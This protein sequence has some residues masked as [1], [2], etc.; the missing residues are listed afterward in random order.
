MSR[1]AKP[2]PILQHRDAAVGHRRVRHRVARAV[3]RARRVPQQLERVGMRGDEGLEL[4]EVADERAQRLVRR[5]EERVER[6]VLHEHG[7][8]VARDAT[9]VTW[10][11]L[12]TILSRDTPGAVAPRQNHFTWVGPGR[13]GTVS[14]DR[15]SS[16]PVRPREPDLTV[17]GGLTGPEGVCTTGLVGPGVFGDGVPGMDVCASPD[18]ANAMSQM[19]AVLARFMRLPSW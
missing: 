11:A 14:G 5:G 7:A 2:G 15:S 18:T 17:F 9:A 12:G 8:V 16:L 3:L 19:A 6:D 10:I 4:T 1:S 13:G